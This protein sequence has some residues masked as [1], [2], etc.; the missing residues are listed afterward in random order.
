M[1][2]DRGP[3]VDRAGLDEYGASLAPLWGDAACNDWMERFS[4]FG[5]GGYQLVSSFIRFLASS[6]TLS[7]DMVTSFLFVLSSITNYL[8]NALFIGED[9]R[10][11]LFTVLKLCS[12]P[13]YNG[14]VKFQLDKG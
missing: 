10:Y 6:V 8:S 1:S 9:L 12:G 11:N 7:S 3:V 13:F 2:V 14:T 4:G 5:K